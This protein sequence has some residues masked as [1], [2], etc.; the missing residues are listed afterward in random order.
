M[1]GR[2]WLAVVATV[3]L[4]SGCAGLAGGAVVNEQL[5][6]GERT[7]D[8]VETKVDDINADQDE[9]QSQLDDVTSEAD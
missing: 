5:E 2:R 9:R 7:I 6:T 8:R 1:D 4:L 3:T